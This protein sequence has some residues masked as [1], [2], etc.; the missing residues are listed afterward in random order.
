MY[1][2]EVFADKIEML[3]KEIIKNYKLKKNLTDKKEKNKHMKNFYKT[4]K[5]KLL[6]LT[7][8]K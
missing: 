1:S 4:V 2:S 6:L 7:K 8:I 5:E 3:Y